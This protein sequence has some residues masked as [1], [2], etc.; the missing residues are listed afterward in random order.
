MARLSTLLVQRSL[1]SLADVEEA[2]ARQVL[3]GGDLVSNF[4]E[5][6]PGPVDERGLTAATAEAFDLDEFLVGPLPEASTTLRES[7]PREL[8]V[9]HTVHPLEWS[10]DLLRLAVAEPLTPD[11]EEDLAFTLGVRIVQVGALLARIREA[12]SRDFGFALDRRSA[13]A[14]ARLRGLPDPSP[15]RLPS[16]LAGAPELSMLPRPA[17][18]PP[19]GDFAHATLFGDEGGGTD[20]SVHDAVTAPAPSVAT[21]HEL[22]TSP[23]WPPPDKDENPAPAPSPTERLAFLR[24]DPKRSEPEAQRRRHRGPYTA[25]EAEETL[26]AAEER[27][28]VLGAFFDF[29]AQYFDYAAL[30]AIVGD[31]AEGRDAHGSGASLAD[32][33]G[34]G[35]PLDLPSVLAHARDRQV[36]EVVRMSTEGLDLQLAH[37]LKR[38]PG[39]PVL[40]MPISVRGRA[41][42]V[43]IG[44]DGEG[45]LELPDF[46]DVL[47]FAP[48]VASALENVI[49]R[50]KAAARKAAGQPLPTAARAGRKERSRLPTR[51][52][53]AAA[54][55]EA[56]ET[57][58]V[59]SSPSPGTRAPNPSAPV[60]QV[61]VPKPAHGTANQA[62]LASK[63]PPKPAIGAASSRPPSGGRWTAHAPE[64]TGAPARSITPTPMTL[65]TPILIDGLR[66]L[67]EESWEERSLE[68]KPPPKPAALDSDAPEITIGVEDVDDVLDGGRRR[69]SSTEPRPGKR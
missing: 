54:L 8:A 37:D 62:P 1:A 60:T 13:R 67:D 15:S 38:Q 52:A 27:D 31:I 50:K 11:A 63:A 48:L 56:L 66:E 35:V 24:A 64:P 57:Q 32:V 28:E 23:S 2:L 16:P 26:L 42:V 6:A 68:A 49:R 29:A 30:F 59:G 14:L 20:A 46:G 10:G 40:V 69:A 65:R 25:A 5:K 47:A 21:V 34:I 33:R 51:D 36:A 22:P 43:L 39:R 41:V 45:A 7:M 55:A 12:L 58:N 4:L 9:R 18:I 44:D 19:F 61:A 17:S 3:Y 53:R